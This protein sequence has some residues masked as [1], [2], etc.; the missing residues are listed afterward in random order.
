MEPRA[1]ES[2]IN[3]SARLTVALFTSMRSLIKN[4]ELIPDGRV[5]NALEDATRLHMRF[6]RLTFKVKSLDSGTITVQVVQGKNPN[7][8]YL[9]KN[10]LVELT[11]E[12]F[13]Q[14]FESVIVHPIPYVSAPAEDVTPQWLVD[15]IKES[16][17]RNKDIATDLGI[18]GIELSDYASG[19][20]SMSIRVRSMFF[21]YFE[22][23]RLSR[24][25]SGDC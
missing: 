7:G 6:N 10:R 17:R 24:M 19:R 20:R 16:G 1:S 9:S 11:R 8:N 15:R 21:Y 18:S 23:L 5:R 14:Y 22:W 13:G 3:R 25:Q 12:L 4:L 2:G